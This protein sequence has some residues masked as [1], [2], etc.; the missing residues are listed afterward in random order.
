MF[1]A[2]CIG[3]SDIIYCL[4]ADGCNFCSE[5]SLPR[6][7][8]A[9]CFRWSTWRP[10]WRYSS[11]TLSTMLK[12]SVPCLPQAQGLLPCTVMQRWG[13]PLGE[14][15]LTLQDK[16]GPY[17]WPCGGKYHACWS[18]RVGNKE[19]SWLQTLS[20]GLIKNLITIRNCSSRCFNWQFIIKNLMK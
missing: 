7:P 18:S 5:M 4:L 16:C 19:G 1:L 15:T 6:M 12:G 8:L 11:S 20:T 10:C 2:L 13:H 9:S 3:C 17:A 14:G